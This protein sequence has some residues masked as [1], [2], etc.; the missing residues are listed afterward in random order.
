MKRF[1]A[2]CLVLLLCGCTAREFD[3]ACTVTVDCASV[4]EQ[5]DES[6][7]AHLPQ[8]G[9][10]FSGEVEFASGESLLDVFTRA[11]RDAKIPAVREGAYLS[12]IGGIAAGDFGPLSGWLFMVNGEFVAEGCD[13]FFLKDGDTVAWTYITEWTE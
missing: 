1:L 5:A 9:M 2:I 10:L 8:D 7:K 6:L 4:L 11:M 13:E 12:S 3:A